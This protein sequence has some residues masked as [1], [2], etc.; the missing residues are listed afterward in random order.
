MPGHA[1]RRSN[2]KSTT[3]T[4]T[5]RGSVEGGSG[6]RR[7]RGTTL[8]RYGLAAVLPEGSNNH[9]PQNEGSLERPACNFA[10]FG[11][12]VGGRRVRR[13]FVLAAFGVERMSS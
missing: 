12:G 9:Y 5:A 6:I 13:R 10:V 1:P 11:A 7:P 8:P 2:V 3:W 4:C